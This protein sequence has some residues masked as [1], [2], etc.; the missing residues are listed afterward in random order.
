MPPLPSVPPVIVP[1][2]APV[3]APP[4]APAPPP[5]LDPSGTVYLEFTKGRT[6][7]FWEIAWEGGTV[8]TSY[9]RVDHPPHHQTE[10]FED[11][12]DAARFVVRQIAAKREKGYVDEV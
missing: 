1:G 7:R 12:V 11:P 6:L 3:P 10:T 2:A 5:D 4:P 8:H 9:G